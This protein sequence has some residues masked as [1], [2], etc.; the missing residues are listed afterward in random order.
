MQRR[1]AISL[2]AFLL[3]GPLLAQTPAQSQTGTPAAPPPPPDRSGKELERMRSLL[4]QMQTNLASL[5][6]GY[7]AEKHQFE[8]E[9]D[10][11]RLLLNHIERGPGVRSGPERVP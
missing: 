4:S 8:L 2:S 1:K 11:W 5:P 10:M 9:I 6:S 7:S 3:A